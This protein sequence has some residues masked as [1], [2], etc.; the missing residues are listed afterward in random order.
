MNTLNES[1]TREKRIFHITQFIWYF[2]SIIEILLLLRFVLKL[3]QANTNA[4]FTTL[5]YQLSNVFTQPFRYVFSTPV[6]EGS[7][8]EWSTLLAMFVYWLLALGI[9]QL[10]CMGRPISHED[11]KSKLDEEEL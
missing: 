5:I 7:I 1:G 9:V 3:L 2:L 11:A 8:F 10:I 6:V 4:T